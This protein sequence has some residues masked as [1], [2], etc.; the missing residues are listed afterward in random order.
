MMTKTQ[1]DWAAQHDWFEAADDTTGTVWVRGDV[2]EPR[3]IQFTDYRALKAW[4]GY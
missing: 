1:I 3:M 4:A 2:G